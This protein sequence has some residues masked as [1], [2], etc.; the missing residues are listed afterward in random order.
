MQ[1]AL[2][3]N[4]LEHRMFPPASGK[5]GSLLSMCIRRQEPAFDGSRPT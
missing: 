4:N 3:H 2:L 5:A 1:H